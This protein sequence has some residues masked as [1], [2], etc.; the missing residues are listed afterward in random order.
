[1]FDPNF[2]GIY[3]YPYASKAKSKL[4]QEIENN[5]D[6]RVVGGG[7]ITLMDF[8][9]RGIRDVDLIVQ[10]INNLVPEVAYKFT[11]GGDDSDGG[12]GFHNSFEIEELWGIIYN[13]GEGVIKHNHFPWCMS[14]CY[15]V[16]VPKNCVPFILEGKR[17]KPIEG[18]MIIFPSFLYH[19]A[20]PS[21]CDGRC[22]IAGNIRTSVDRHKFLL[23]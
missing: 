9:K 18:R 23:H 5:L 20:P 3:D 21:K 12:V 7:Y 17:I 15:F 11:Q 22:V 2:I 16:N 4:Y 1:M 8:H 6:H 13:K 14:F 10:W 19:L